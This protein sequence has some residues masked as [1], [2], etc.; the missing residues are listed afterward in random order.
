LIST[1]YSINA[2]GE[3]IPQDIFGGIYAMSTATM[4]GQLAY[5]AME[6]MVVG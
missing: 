4:A 6:Q 3:V 1:G 5:S 2:F